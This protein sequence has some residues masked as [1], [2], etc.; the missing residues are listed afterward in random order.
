M[1]AKPT[2]TSRLYTLRRTGLTSALGIM[3]VL[4]VAACAADVP[5]GPHALAPQTSSF[6]RA[7]RLEEAATLGSASKFAVLGAS[8]V[9]CTGAGTN[10]GD[11][12][13]SPGSSI[14]G[15]NPDCTLTGAIHSADDAAASA[16]GDAATAYGNLSAKPCDRTFGTVQ[17]LSG[18]TLTPGVY[19]FPSSAQISGGD[20]TLSGPGTFIFKVSSTFI[21]ST[22]SAVVLSGGANCGN[23]YWLVGSSSTLGGP[24][25]GNIIAY[26]SIGFNPGATLAGRAIALNAAV[27]MSGQ[28]S[29]TPC[30]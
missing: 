17:E 6:N 16:Q 10:T 24:V 2:S 3:T 14:T 15:F 20:L 1:Y 28:N 12:G 25:S 8:T 30:R 27:T 7:T 22:G 21:T 29:V 23:I 19:C 18:I 9:T 5:S 26:T 11:V 13:V 4:V